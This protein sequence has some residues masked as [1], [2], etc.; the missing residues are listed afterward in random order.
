MKRWYKMAITIIAVMAITVG[1]IW[2]AA[3]EVFGI[4]YPPG[5]PKPP[6]SYR[7]K[8]VFGDR[9]HYTVERTLT[10]GSKV[11]VDVTGKVI[12]ESSK[13]L[14]SLLVKSL[15]DVATNVNEVKTDDG[16]TYSI[17]DP[18]QWAE[19]LVSDLTII[20]YSAHQL[21]EEYGND[22]QL[23]TDKLNGLETTWRIK[24]L[25][26]LKKVEQREVVAFVNDVNRGFE[27]VT[28]GMKENNP[29]KIERARDI[30]VKLSEL[31]PK[32][33]PSK[34]IMMEDIESKLLEGYKQVTADEAERQLGS[35]LMTPKYLP[36]RFQ[37]Y[38]IFMRDVPG[39]PTEKMIKQVWYDPKSFELLLVTQ[40]KIS[41]PDQEG[42][43]IFTDGLETPGK[44]SDIFPWAK[45]RCQYE[46]TKN[47][48][49]VQGY[50]LVNDEGKRDEYEKILKSLKE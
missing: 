26:F 49:S 13:Q 15:T 21:L 38:G 10:D 22:I 18:Q 42:Q 30:F 20:I 27:L 40:S 6:L 9:Q 39:I 48:I 16:N 45:Y 14:N 37:H 24:I 31:L 12:D 3:P 11:Q 41:A 2:L 4:G 19:Y 43:I 25:P 23:V 17:K 32:M 1:V 7:I 28:E 36:E 5:V 29:Q 44:I 46:F 50:M 34:E 33:P 35:A 8:A 47:G